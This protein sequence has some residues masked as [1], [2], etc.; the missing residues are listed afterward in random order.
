MDAIAAIRAIALYALAI[1]ETQPAPEPD[2]EPTPE[3]EPVPEP[4]PTPEP[5]PEPEP[6]PEPEPTPDPVP[7]PA[8]VPAPVPGGAVYGSRTLGVDISTCAEPGVVVTASDVTINQ[9]LPDFSDWDIGARRLIL[10]AHV[11]HIADVRSINGVSGSLPLIQCLGNGGFGTA[12]YISVLGCAGSMVFKQENL[13][14]AGIFHAWDMRGMSQDGIK[15]CGGNVVD[16]CRISDATFRGGT[17]HS[18]AITLM[19]AK[20]GVTIIGN[21]ID[22]KY[23]G[24]P[25]QSGINNWFRIETYPAASNEWDDIVIEGN[26][27]T[28]ANDRSFAMQVDEKNSPI[29]RGSIKVR[30]N[31][32]DKAGGVRKILYAPSAR[33]SEWIGNK[34]ASGADIPLSAA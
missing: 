17:P 14:R 23:A 34:D 24:Q 10:R 33:I 22:W 12:E 18:D 3:P 32:M 4:E 28:H 7:T 6:V 19:A 26:R 20:G 25:D 11:D 31:V 1:T 15:L 13:S 9:A 8:P 5:I 21:E 29:W 27:L 16:S 30:N 2:P